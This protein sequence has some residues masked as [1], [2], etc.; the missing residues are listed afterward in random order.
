MIV[1][2]EHAFGDRRAAD[3]MK[4]V[5]ARDDVA[6][7]RVL[8]VA[9]AVADRRPVAIEPFERRHLGLELDRRAVRDARR[10]QVLHD[11]LLA[12]DRHH[13]AGDQLGEMHVD[14]LAVAEADV[15]RLV[16]HAFAPQ[17][18]VE[19]ELGHQ[20]DGAL[21]QHAGAHAIFHIGAAA[22]FEHDAVDALAIEQMREEQPG[23]PRADDADLRVHFLSLSAGRNWTAA[24]TPFS[25]AIRVPLGQFRERARPG[26]QGIRGTSGR[27]TDGAGNERWNRDRRKTAAFALAMRRAGARRGRDGRVGAVRALGR[28]RALCERVLARVSGAAVPVGLDAARE[29]ADGQRGRGSTARC[30]SRACSSPATCSSGI[31]RSSARRSRT[32]RS[33]P[34]RRRSGSRSARGSCSPKRSDGRILIGLALCLAGRLR[35]ARRELRLRAAAAHRATSTASRPRSSSAPMCWRCAPRARAMARPN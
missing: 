35:A 6:G 12:V 32:R 26:T 24:R 1:G 18:L 14:Q 7:Q 15:D 16:D 3:A 17:P 30:C 31:S 29:R 5:A 21:L 33:S 2:G 10:D 9:L 22:R 11:L 25:S 19:P 34:P 23:R 8:G 4:A 27:S 28:C 20:V 13:L